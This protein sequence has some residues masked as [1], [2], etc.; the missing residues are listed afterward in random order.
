MTVKVTETTL[1][2]TATVAE[3]VTS[4]EYSV[5]IAGATLDETALQTAAVS[6]GTATINA[7]GLLVGEEY[8]I[9]V[10]A[11]GTDK[12]YWTKVTKR[13]LCKLGGLPYTENF[14][15][16]TEGVS[17]DYESS[18]SQ[19]PA[20]PATAVYP[21][22]W[23]V[24]G[25]S[26]YDEWEEMY[27]Y[28]AHMAEI[29]GASKD[30]ASM[31]LYPQYGED[32]Y[33]VLPAFGYEVNK[34]AL[35]FSYKNER[36]GTQI[37]VGV[38]SNPNDPNTF[39]QVYKPVSAPAWAD[40]SVDFSSVQDGYEHI[41]I[42][43]D[44]DNGWYNWIDDIRVAC[45]G[46]PIPVSGNVCVGQDFIYAGVVISADELNIG[47]NRITRREEA[48]DGGCDKV[49]DFTITVDTQAEMVVYMDTVCPGETEYNNYG[50]KIAN[51]ESKRYYVETMTA[52]AACSQ[53][54]CLKLTVAYPTKRINEVICEDVLKAGYHFDLAG[55]DKVF[56]EP[57][58]YE[59]RTQSLTTDCDSVVIL[60]L[61]A[62]SSRV[63]RYR[64]ICEGDSVLFHGKQY[65]TT[66]EY[67]HNYGVQG[68]CGDSAEVLHLTVLPSN[69]V[70]DTTICPNGR[71]TDGVYFGDRYITY[72]GTY[73]RTYENKLE[74]EVSETWNISYAELNKVEVTD[75]VCYNED[76]EVIYNNMS[77]ETIKNVTE[78]QVIRMIVGATNTT[79]GDSLILNLIVEKLEPLHKDT[80]VNELPFLWGDITV[81]SEGEWE[82]TF[83][84]QHGCD[85]TVILNVKYVSSLNIAHAGEL[86]LRPNPVEKDQVIAVDYNF[87]AQEREGMIIEVVNSLG[88]VVRRQPAAEVVV[89]EPIRVSGFYTVRFITGE[90]T[91]YTA[92]V[93]VK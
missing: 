6:N 91:Y 21:E 85:S 39:V 14:N 64:E 46:E 13:T 67:T 40:A 86:T 93:L 51:P 54:V 42:K 59:L 78:N 88:Q 25:G 28:N 52:D 60:N 16:Y 38:M 83:M 35:S 29:E 63:H 10:R 12:S 65:S 84:S 8:D 50:F 22:C 75:Y 66:G 73:T 19:R 82:Q 23:T 26:Y 37:E 68:I 36:E 17:M 71:E 47:E 3:G 77:Y 74:C 62:L 4:V 79:C 27:F 32:L 34:L 87:S 18:Y 56:T 9:Y 41:V 53:I 24:L 31:F 80:V 92:K 70:L 20:N 89:V 44:A 48:L 58:I 69:I 33:M 1:T 30:G 81:A 49:Y 7:N 61:T 2:A 55:E 11:I 15:S 5:I 76:Y 72:P 43:V 90:N 45:V 57:G